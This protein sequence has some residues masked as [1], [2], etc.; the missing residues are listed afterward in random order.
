[1]LANTHPLISGKTSQSAL[2]CAFR[3]EKPKPLPVWF[4]R[5][6]GRSLP[7]YRKIREGRSML[8]S[9]L[10]PELVHEITMQPVRRHGVDAAIFF[11]DIVIPLKLS[12]VEVEIVPNVGPVIA[13][14]VRTR[15][16][17][18]KLGDLSESALSPIVQAV[19]KLV[20]TLDSTPL[21]GFGGAP[22]TLASYL[23]EGGPSKTLP[24]SRAMMES[25]PE[26]WTDVL[27]WCADITAKFIRSQVTAGASALQVFDSWAGRLTEDEY[28]KF[29]APASRR[30]FDQLKDLRYGEHEVPR[31]HF[32]LGTEELL[33][34]ML[35]VGA[36]ALGVDY[37]S[38]LAEV[39]ERFDDQLVLQGNIDP[40]LLDQDF[41]QLEQHI[42]E[43]LAKGSRAKG[44]IV[45]L[46]HGVP[47]TTDPEV[48]TKIVELVHRVSAN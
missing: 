1:V 39:S 32:G 17:F 33:P 38:D 3:G 11:S 26:L 43:V 37:L 22:F 42:L 18:Q 35:E 10:D 6:A 9:C 2:L 44:H 13:N 46:G 41:A 27:D 8:E 16:D 21:I 29:A 31:V 5:Q 19:S 30:L 28:L 36:T 20:A 48:L 40:K 23:I 25:D 45:N 47:P 12:G 7:E 34:H 14:P 4:M 15:A 24:E